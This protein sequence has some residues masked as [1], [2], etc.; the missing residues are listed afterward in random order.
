[1]VFL[2]NMGLGGPG[3]F[4]AF[5]SPGA[6]TSPFLGAGIGDGVFSP[7]FSGCFFPS[8]FLSSCPW[9][10]FFPLSMPGTG[11]SGFLGKSGA[12][13]LIDFP[14]WGAEDFFTSS[15]HLRLGGSS[16]KNKSPFKKGTAEILLALA[17]KSRSLAKPFWMRSL[18]SGDSFKRSASLPCHGL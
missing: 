5:F 2:L 7:F 14:F 8:C 15:S 16:F 18:P 1:M 4:L 3:A 6:F 12:V 11:C 17:Q 9:A 10:P 13:I